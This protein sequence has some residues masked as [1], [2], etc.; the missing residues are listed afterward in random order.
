[1]GQIADTVQPPATLIGIRAADNQCIRSSCQW[2]L[3]VSCTHFL[4]RCWSAPCCSRWPDRPWLLLLLLL[5]R[6]SRRAPI[7]HSP[8]GTAHELAGDIAVDQCRL[9]GSSPVT[10]A[11]AA[12]NASIHHRKGDVTAEVAI[13]HAEALPKKVR[14]NAADSAQQRASTYL[15]MGCFWLLVGSLV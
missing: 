6:V 4:P 12:L 2:S 13:Q 10:P 5:V 8:S 1:M 7:L 9:A 14:R 11:C 15:Q 3:I